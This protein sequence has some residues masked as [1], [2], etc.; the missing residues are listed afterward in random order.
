MADTGIDQVLRGNLTP[1]QY[2]AATDGTREVLALACAGSGKSRTLAYRIARLIAEGEPPDSVVAFT[3]TEKAA[4]SIKLRVSQ[5]L[6]AAGL[7]PLL[8]GAMYLGTIHAYCQLVLGSIDARYR[9][10]DV[11]DENRLVLYVIS[12]FYD[13]ESQPLQAAHGNARYFETVRRVSQAWTCTN[14]ELINLEDVATADGFLG[15]V[16][17]NLNDRLNADQYLDFSLM[18]RLVAD[19]IERGDAG[20][21]AA[22]AGLRHLM[23]DEYQDVNPAQEKLIR[24]LHQRSQTLFVVGDDDQAIYGWRGADVSNI[25]TFADRYPNSSSHTVTENFR[26]TTAIVRTADSF[27]AAELGPGRLTKNPVAVDRGGPESFAVLWFPSRDEEARWVAERID[28]M[29]GST[30]TEP[31]GVARGLTPADFAILMRSTKMPEADGR[32]RHGPFTEALTARG[33]PFSLEAGGGIFDRP[34]VAAVREILELL[35]NSS[36]TRDQ[37]RAVYDSAVAPAF[38]NATFARV[39]DVLASWG[40]RIHA[41]VGTRQRVY[42]QQ[43]VHELLQAFGLADQPLD[44]GAMRDLGTLSQVIQDVETVYMSVDTPSRYREILNFL[45]NH[46][47]TGYDASTDDIVRRPDAVTVSTVHKMKGLEFPAVFVADVER[48]RFPK[49]NRAYD[50]WLP[51]AVISS[52]LARGAYQTRRGDEARLFYTA[53]TRAERYLHISGS[54]SLPAGVQRHA[55][56]VFVQRLTD[57]SITTDPASIPAGLTQTAPGRRLDETVVPTTYSDIRYYLRCPR[58]YQ[59]RKGY[60]FSPAITDMFGFG[61]TVHAA[62]GKLHET[63]DRAPSV[64]EATSLARD[65]YHVKH[66]PPS[67]DPTNRPGAYERGRDSAGRMVGEYAGEYA[68]DFAH[69][70]EVE[71][72]FEIPLAQCVISGA[73]DLLIEEN[74]AGDIVDARIIDFK[75]MRGGDAPREEEAL[76]WTDFALQV[77]LYAKAAREVLGENA[78]TGAVH[79]LKDNQRVDVPVDEDAVS[80]AVANV[81]WAVAGILRGDYPMRPHPSKCA[82]CDFARLCPKRP[83]QFSVAD[84]PPDIAVPS[85]GGFLAARAFSEY[86]GPD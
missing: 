57:P 49:N 10:Y 12:R 52:A 2:Q 73:I 72:R 50:G 6:D 83:E 47:E 34:H 63:F 30:Y 17:L 27:A 40:R 67:R 44:P 55:P 29:L 78:R 20:A 39:A 33:I 41:P 71:V 77:Q 45:Q 53:M 28:V 82:A 59:L 62:V 22:V 25:L 7:D 84:R 79:L 48:P 75:A 51:P 70:R 36:P 26:S 58:D 35:R 74:E 85:A 16:L 23:V 60:G 31:N 14:D 66:V 80:R 5:A 69:R 1:P 61:M 4:E 3:F 43:L 32:P 64:A 68:D 9:Q 21:E 11:L 76:H 18:V 65:M 13:L 19:A 81:E 15:R 38:P 8:V 54:E 37:L 24:E 56:S 86:E 42:P 46:A